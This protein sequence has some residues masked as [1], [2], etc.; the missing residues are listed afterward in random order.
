[1]PVTVTRLPDEPI[2]LAQ[3]YDRMDLATV[4]DLYDQT[5]LCI[6][7]MEGPIYHISCFVDVDASIRDLA[8]ALVESSRRRQGSVR[9][10]RL[11][12]IMVAGH[13]RLRLLSDAMREKEFGGL[14]VP[15]FDTLDEALS[16][17]RSLIV[18]RGLAA[19]A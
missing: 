10:P 16:Y 1:M 17:A 12:P 5:A 6:D 13:N 7:G 11:T 18:S 9:D 3:V 19:Q 8:L 4:R 15:V 2:V 14:D